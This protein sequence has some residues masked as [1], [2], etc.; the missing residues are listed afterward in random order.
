METDQPKL[1]P[2]VKAKW[3]AALRSG[4]FKQTEGRL[5][6]ERG[7]C[8][9]GVLCEIYKEEDADYAARCQPFEGGGGAHMYDGHS[10]IPPD[11]VARWAFSWSVWPD[12]DLKIK[13]LVCSPA[14]H[15]DKWGRTFEEIA[16]AI[17][18]QL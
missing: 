5:A 2:E 7:F 12:I 14:Q 8:C 11:S 1:V 3:V 6:D 10:G 13:D 15:N 9:L 4:K 16:D 17:E 18:E